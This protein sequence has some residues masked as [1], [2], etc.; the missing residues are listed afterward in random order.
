IVVGLGNPGP[1]YE[2]TRHN[3]GFHVLDHLALHEG[4]LFQT[5]RN[6]DSAMEA[7]DFDLDALLVMPT[8]FMNASG[9]VVAP[10]AQWAGV[11]PEEILVVYDDLDLDPGRLRLRPHGGAGGQKG[12]RSIIDRLGSDRFPRLRIGIGRPRTD[13]ARHVLEVITGAER[14]EMEISIAQASEAVHDW[15]STG[16]IE[17]CMTRFHSRWNQS[18]G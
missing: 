11:A 15:L 9:E 2:W 18:A 8:T 5:A 4:L 6:L 14:E 1:E 7:G 12:M 16:D 3:V 17:G 13:A 10:L